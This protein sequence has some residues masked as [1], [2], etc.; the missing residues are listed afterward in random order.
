MGKQNDVRLIA[1]FD[2]LT[3]DLT[4]MPSSV[5]HIQFAKQRQLDR[6]RK[7]A[8]MSGQDL[9]GEAIQKFLDCN[10]S[11]GNVEIK[12]SSE[13]I[14]DARD[15]LLFILE[16]N[17]KKFDPDSLQE[18][19]TWDQLCENWG[20]GKG[21]SNGVPGSG[22]LEKID[23]PMSVT[24]DAR[25]LVKSL[26]LRDT[27]F[28]CFDALNGN[29]GLLEVEGSRIA[30]VPKNETTDR[31]I[32]IEP[33]GNMALQLAAGRIIEQALRMIGL[34][35]R[36]QQPKNKAMARRGSLYGD[37]CTID[38]SMASDRIL[39]ELVRLI[40]PPEWY[41]LLMKLRSPQMV[42]KRSTVQLNMISTMGNGFT[43]PLMTMTILMLIYANR[44]SRGGPYRFIDWS[45]TAV[46]GDDIIVPVDEY[47]SL[48]SQLE[49]A[50]LLV[51]HNKSYSEG[52]FRES[53]GG[54]YVNGYD[55]TPFYVKTLQTPSDIYVAINQM[56][57]WLG[58]HYLVAP[59][60]LKYL[61]GL[62]GG[63]V[64]KVP[65]WLGDTAGVRT[66]LCPRRYK[67]L[68]PVQVWVPFGGFSVMR[69]VC[70]GYLRTLG[71]STDPVGL[72]RETHQRYSVG[73]A[74]LPKSYLDGWDPLSRT[75][76]ESAHVSFLMS[77]VD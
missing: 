3:A 70:G 56:L 45:S 14:Q 64:L 30:T 15:Y 52:P 8:L 55:V 20:Y 21:T 53:C 33:S 57:G 19:F 47:S 76:R 44:R 26:R 29:D 36:T 34:D 16:R 9:A 68:K 35:I 60:S 39:P 59:R 43:F 75:Q 38:L 48:C 22:A 65:E 7:R 31:T 61:V 74:R 42:V 32:A 10:Q 24:P 63:K 37:L 12:L 69:M 54:D 40:W 13:I 71:D 27:Y 77:M 41:D 66:A 25:P 6:M 11:L 73:D 1:F 49:A 23:L 18:T 5:Q 4:E 50:G 28:R 46:F 72:R 17:C 2:L 51:N 58:R 67:Y 62:L